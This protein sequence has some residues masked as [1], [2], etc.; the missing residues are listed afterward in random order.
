M[1]PLIVFDAIVN[2]SF[3]YLAR[4]PNLT[5]FSDLLDS[6]FRRPTEKYEPEEDPGIIATLTTPNRTIHL[7]EF[8]K[9]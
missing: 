2:V 9:L 4:L 8:A 6:A 7:P 5:N 3:L 1:M